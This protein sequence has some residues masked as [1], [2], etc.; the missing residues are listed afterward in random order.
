M[1]QLKKM[2]LINLNTTIDAA[3]PWTLLA[4]QTRQSRKT[5]WLYMW[6]P[7]TSVENVHNNHHAHSAIT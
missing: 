6:G 5:Q 7:V 4:I 1:A 3:G 2:E